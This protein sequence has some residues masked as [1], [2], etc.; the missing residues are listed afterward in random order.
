MKGALIGF[1]L[2]LILAVLAGSW[3]WLEM[4]ANVG[5]FIPAATFLCPAFCLWRRKTFTYSV[6]LKGQV[7][8]LIVLLLIYNFDMGALCAVPAYLFREGF[9]GN[10]LTP[11]TA[12]LVVCSIYL[13]G[14]LLWIFN[15]KQ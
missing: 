10:G 7:A 8:L 3:V 5:F 13:G 14:N 12:G 4:R 9:H 1:T 11:A 6:F 2:G 15:R